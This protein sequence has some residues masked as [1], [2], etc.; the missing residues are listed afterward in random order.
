[1]RQRTTTYREVPQERLATAAA[2]DGVC[3][4]VRSPLPVLSS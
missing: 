2:S 1:M 4:S 3:A